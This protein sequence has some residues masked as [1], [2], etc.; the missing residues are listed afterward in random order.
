MSCDVLVQFGIWH[1]YGSASGVDSMGEVLSTSGTHC[2]L[3]TLLIR[4]MGAEVGAAV[5]AVVV[6]TTTTIV[7]L[8]SCSIIC[9]I[10]IIDD[11]V[12]ILL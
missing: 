8:N 11:S 10:I 7:C 6:A 1:C 4:R 5:D 12:G 9:S 2:Q 3:T